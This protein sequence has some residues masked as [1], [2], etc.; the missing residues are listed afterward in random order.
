MPSKVYAPLSKYSVSAR[1]EPLGL[2]ERISPRI[3]PRTNAAQ[4]QRRRPTVKP[5]FEQLR[6]RPSMTKEEFEANMEEWFEECRQ[7]RQLSELVQQR[8]LLD[9]ITDAPPPLADRIEPRE[10][11][12]EPPAPLPA[13]FVDQK[14]K[15]RPLN[16]HKTKNLH[17]SRPINV[18]KL[19]TLVPKEEKDGL[20]ESSEVVPVID[21]L[22]AGYT[23]VLGN[24]QC[25]FF[26]P[27]GRVESG[28]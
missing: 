25:V 14:G 8:H 17:F 6:K 23:K 19:W 11:T 13:T 28:S 15:E 9:R 12:Y 5:K 1:Y 20:T 2:S 3:T 4:V 10:P 27:F 18:D 16:F 22:A 26:S 21:T 24:G 7:K